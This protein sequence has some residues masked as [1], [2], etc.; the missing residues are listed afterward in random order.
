MVKVTE[1]EQRN[2]SDN[3]IEKYI[4]SSIRGSGEDK[5]RARR[6]QHDQFFY[7]ALFFSMPIMGEKMPIL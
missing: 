4:F 7:L 6:A 3:L 5:G 1:K 2:S